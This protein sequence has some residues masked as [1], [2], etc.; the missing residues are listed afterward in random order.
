M[1]RVRSLVGPFA[2]RLAPAL[3]LLL[4]PSLLAGACDGGG[5][6]ALPPPTS[7][8]EGAPLVA[9]EWGT[10]T[11][12]LA[13]DGRSMPGLL[14]EDEPPPPFVHRRFLAPAGST[15]AGGELLAA[16][17]NQ[18]METPVIY[19]YSDVARA[20]HVDVG[21]PTGIVTEWSPDAVAAAPAAA[22][23]PAPL[24]VGG[25]AMS[26]DVELVPGLTDL[27]LVNDGYFDVPARQVASTPLRHATRPTERDR[28]IFYRGVANFDTPLSVRAT[29]AGALTIANGGDEPLP[30]AF[31]LQVDADGGSVTA[32]GAIAPESRAVVPTADREPMDAYLAHA[33]AE[34]AVALRATGLYDDEAQA[35]VDT[36]SR[37]Y[38]RTG[39]VRILY[40]LPRAWTDALLPLRLDP[41]PR[42]L[43]RTLVG[44]VEVLT[45]GE[46]QRLAGD[47]ERAAA[48]G[49]PYEMAALGSFAEPKL[50]RAHELVGTTEARSY[51]EA[52]IQKAVD[53]P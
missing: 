8:P 3:V 23:P 32:L 46:E 13:S 14:H 10:F 26:W 7:A 5:P 45:V 20:V 38:F 24:A 49:P 29:A 44:R 9:H 53:L 4:A 15:R 35:M 43:V 27:P 17:V 42:E 41:T 21:F 28:F 2:A 12:V 51:S 40:V 18:R 25:G 1:S 30:A 16:N 47:I 22:T 48:G 39:G 50:R 52:L 31:L 36:W 6:R 33:A 37:S 19:F 34:L 11:S